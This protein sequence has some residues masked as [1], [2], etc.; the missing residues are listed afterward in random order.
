MW[1]KADDPEDPKP[2]LKSPFTFSAVETSI[3]ELYD[4]NLSLTVV[5]WT[6]KGERLAPVIE[7]IINYPW[8]KYGFSDIIIK[9]FQEALITG[10]AIMKV[11]YQKTERGVKLRRMK[12]F[13]NLTKAQK[14]R[15]RENKPIYDE[16]TIV[17][18]NDVSYEHVPLSEYY[19]DDSAR[20]Q[21]GNDYAAGDGIRERVMSMDQFMAEYSGNPEVKNLDKVRLGKSEDVDEP[22]FT[23]PTD[24]Y[25]D[26]VVVVREWERKWQ[27]SLRV[28]ANGV[29]I[30]DTPLPGNHKQ[31]SYVLFK[32]I[33]IPHQYYGMGLADI[34]EGLQSEDE[35]HRNKFLELLDIS[36]SPP[37]I[38]N[39][40]VSG[41][42]ADQYDTVKMGEII[43]ISGSPQDIQ[44]MAPP[45]SRLSEMLAMRSQIREDTIMVSLIDPKASALPTKTPT[46][47]EAMQ[48]TQA[49][50]K[51][52]MKTLK[53]LAQGMK[54]AG[55]LQWALQKQ[56]YPVQMEPESMKARQ[57]MENSRVV[58]S[59]TIMVDG[60][61]IMEQQEGSGFDT[62]SMPGQRFPIEIKDDYFDLE[63]E[64]LDVIINPESMQPLSRLTKARKSQEALAQLA[65]VLMT[66]GVLDNKHMKT[67][68]KDYVEANG[69]NPKVLDTD[70]EDD[71]KAVERAEKQNAVIAKNS[72]ISTTDKDFTIVLGR[73]G[74]P[75]AHT[76][77]HVK[78]LSV[79]AGLVNV[80]T[81][82]L[83][84]NRQ[85]LQVAVDERAKLG[86]QEPFDPN[87]NNKFR[88]LNTEIEQLKKEHQ[89]LADHLE[90][91]LMTQPEAEAKALQPLMGAD[92]Q[93][94]SPPGQ[95]L[96]G[97]VPQG[98]QPQPQGQPQGMP[99]IPIPDLANLGGG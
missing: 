5:P 97:N 17:E 66:P 49:T 19:P 9:V 13:G 90:V 12:G 20:V 4:Q 47:F 37:I 46:A 27:D 83:G 25:E 99:S 7:A 56:E 29:E 70:R 81:R 23:F 53:N 40:M 33:N 65:P 32:A 88:S 14:K 2:N 10:S 57:G 62:E 16:K 55:R 52:W 1:R 75:S 34:M 64:E 59:R 26:S 89:M 98:P 73:P 48:T 50:M 82:E 71:E 51:S 45:I 28:V 54:T 76:T 87:M 93:I 84:R 31:L 15:M 80:K 24:I 6:R 91:D 85:A 95:P 38:A 30:L 92:I 60:M 44:W 94:P 3:A 72:R 67:L 43:S 68:L 8:H 78:R 74:E 63:D 21:H 39:N 22:V 36:L 42:F 86:I 58:K 41:E 79:L 11:K 18:Y 61:K 35:V 77:V 69:I 96:Q